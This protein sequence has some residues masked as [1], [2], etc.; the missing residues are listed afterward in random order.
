MF[1]LGRWVV[2]P[3]I[4]CMDFKSSKISLDLLNFFQIFSDFLDFFPDFF[5]VYGDSMNKK[6]FKH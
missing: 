4:G 1:G 3:Q 5:L 6:G 2:H